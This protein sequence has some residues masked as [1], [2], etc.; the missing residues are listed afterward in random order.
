MCYSNCPFENYL[1]ECTLSSRKKYPPNAHCYLPPEERL[2]N[3]VR[4][5]NEEGWGIDTDD[6]IC[7][8]S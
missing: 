4:K 8:V 6:Y 7:T 3:Y 5:L 2:A 1:G